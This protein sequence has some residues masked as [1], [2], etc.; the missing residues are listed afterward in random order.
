M[1]EWYKNVMLYVSYFYIYDKIG[2]TIR[3]PTSPYDQ[4][5]TS[6]RRNRKKITDQLTSLVVLL[7]QKTF[8]RCVV[9]YIL[10]LI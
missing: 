10:I 2:E 7:M 6:H 8:S 5:I 9:V 3:G 4:C 1:C